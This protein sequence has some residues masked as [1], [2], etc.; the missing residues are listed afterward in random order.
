MM[1]MTRDVYDVHDAGDA[2]W[3]RKNAA[4]LD[5]LEDNQDVFADI[6]EV[7]S[8]QSGGAVWGLRRSSIIPQSWARVSDPIALLL[9]CY[10]AALPRK[11]S[12]MASEA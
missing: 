12:R 11:Y 6:F 5:K 9:Y 4:L 7:R 2:N 10:I 8:Q 3:G 1:C